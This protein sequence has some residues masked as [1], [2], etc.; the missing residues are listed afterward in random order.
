[1][2]ELSLYEI[3]DVSGGKAWYLY[4]AQAVTDFVEGFSDG[5]NANPRPDVDK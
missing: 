2:Q 4:V 3:D 1:M 5:W